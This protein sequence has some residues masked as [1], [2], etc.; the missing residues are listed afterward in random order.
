MNRR[1]KKDDVRHKIGRRIALSKKQGNI[2]M[3]RSCSSLEKACWSAWFFIADI[4]KRS[5]RS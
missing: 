1:E 5:G 3:K 4:K 2:A